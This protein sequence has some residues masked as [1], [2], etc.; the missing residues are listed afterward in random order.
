MCENEVIRCYECGTE[1][2]QESMYYLGGGDYICEDCQNDYYAYCEDCEELTHQDNIIPVNNNSRYVCESCADNYLTCDYCGGLFDEYHI[3]VDSLRMT[4]CEDC[5]NT[6]YFTCEDCGEVY[7]LDEGERINGYY[8]CSSCADYHDSLT[9][10]HRDCIL[11]YSTKPNPIFFGDDNAAGYYGVELE[12]DHGEQRQEAARSIQEA[13]GDH[14][15]IKE[16]GSL[17]YAGMEIVTHPATLDYH[18]NEFP[19]SEICETAAAY[20]YR[21][22]DTDTCG[23]HIHASR[24]LFGATQTEQDLTIAKIMLLIDRW[25]NTYIVKFA[26][27]DLSA[28]R[29]WANK[30]NTDIQPE[31]DEAAAVQKAKKNANDRYRAINLCN[32]NTVEFRL[33]KGTLKKDTIIA[34]IQWV[35]RII[36]YCRNTQLKDLFST[37][38]E[39][40]FGST[41][42]AELTNYLKQRGLYKE[43]EVI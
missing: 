20:G 30:P 41:E 18:V 33:F 13:A 23:L 2:N 4:L 17:T 3:A 37:A 22:H 38:W 5:F 11:S 36:Q 10:N 28:M 19:W 29:R 31:D 42:H 21:S 25:Y 24:S 34:S 43:R 12:I 16:D 26:R 40:I 32:R 35:D 7:H 39:D 9:D 14:I 27:R 1:L 6:H 8:Y 15:Y